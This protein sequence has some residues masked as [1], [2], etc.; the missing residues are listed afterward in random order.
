[1]DVPHVVGRSEHPHLVTAS[2]ECLGS[3]SG[4]VQGRLCCIDKLMWKCYNCRSHLG[5][6]DEGESGESGNVFPAGSGARARG[7]SSGDRFVPAGAGRDGIRSRY[8]EG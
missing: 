6:E 7:R 5:G 8:G 3:L 2:E 4:I 1:M